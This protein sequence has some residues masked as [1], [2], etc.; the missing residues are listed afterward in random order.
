[1]IREAKEQGIEVVDVDGSYLWKK[2][3]S[4]LA[5]LGV[6]VSSNETPLPPPSGWE[7]GTSV[8]LHYNFMTKLI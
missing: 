4:I 3:Q 1:M 7:L 8:N 6:D 5:P 2:R